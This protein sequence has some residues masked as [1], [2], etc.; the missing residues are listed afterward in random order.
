V[1]ASAICTVSVLLPAALHEIGPHRTA[2]GRARRAPAGTGGVVAVDALHSARRPVFGPDVPDIVAR[3]VAGGARGVAGVR[4]LHRAESRNTRRH[5]ARR[6][7]PVAQKVPIGAHKGAPVRPV[8]RAAHRRNTLDAR[9][10]G[11]I[12]TLGRQKSRLTHRPTALRAQGAVDAM[13]PARALVLAALSPFVRT[14][15]RLAGAR[16][17]HGVTRRPDGTAAGVEARGTR[18]KSA[19]KTL[20]GRANGPT[21]CIRDSRE[22]ETPSNRKKKYTRGPGTATLQAFEKKNRVSPNTRHNRIPWR[23]TR[24]ER[25]ARRPRSPSRGAMR[26][27]N[28]RT[29]SPAAP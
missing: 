27:P 29:V 15:G 23:I 3:R 2:E 16:R 26:Q 1:R 25:H 19:E 12:Q 14:N 13:I 22:E 28:L 5:R 11:R 20:H 4:A 18:Q 8:E 17:A 24:H 21:V 9:G 7:A 10:I 6:T